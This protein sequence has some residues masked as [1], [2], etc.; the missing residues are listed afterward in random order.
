MNIKEAKAKAKKNIANKI[1]LVAGITAGV[2]TIVVLAKK[3]HDWR[4]NFLSMGELWNESEENY[5]NMK[6]QYLTVTENYMG[7]MEKVL[8]TLPEVPVEV[9][10]QM[11][12]G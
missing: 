8:D 3:N 10:K 5:A 2:V 1:V 7:L 4:N 6:D 11:D 12:V 9:L